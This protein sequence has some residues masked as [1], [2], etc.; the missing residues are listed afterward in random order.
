MLH[1]CVAAGNP[2]PFVQ[3][4]ARGSRFPRHGQTNGELD[5]LLIGVFCPAGVGHLHLVGLS[6]LIPHSSRAY[7]SMLPS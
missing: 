3:I 5:G 2:M 4:E 7:K 1:L 6:P